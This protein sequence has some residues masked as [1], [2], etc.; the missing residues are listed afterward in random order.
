MG[1]INSMKSKIL[2]IKA[3]MDSKLNW[4]GSNI[5][6]TN[7]LLVEMVYQQRLLQHRN[8]FAKRYAR[9]YFSQTD[10]DGITLEIINRIRSVDPGCGNIF[11]EF[12]VGDGCE[13]NTL[14]LLS[15]GWKGSWFG[16]E[17]LAFCTEDSQSLHFRKS[18]I[19]SENIIEL[20]Q[21]ALQD[22]S[23][24]QLDIISLDLD[25]NDYHFIQ[26]LL[27]QDA[28]PALFICEYNAIFP[29]G[30]DWKAKYNDNFRWTGDHYFGA[31]ISSLVHLFTS[32]GY[33]LCA[34]NP[35]TGANA[36]FVRN[37]YLGLF[38]DIPDRIEDIYVPPFYR[39]DNRFTHAITP[40][41]IRSLFD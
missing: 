20:Y 3:S 10:E 34:C 40:D 27:S 1:I 28:K 18:W 17:D 32:N 33:F 2:T 4:I 29:V 36:F 26:R 21:Q 12:G 22:W 13:N 25:G 30:A 5:L 7:S 35:H 38:P 24:S 15:L 8:E 41:F 37:E 19:T 11:A 6:T 14:V 16:G 31:S 39:G 23:A 9:K